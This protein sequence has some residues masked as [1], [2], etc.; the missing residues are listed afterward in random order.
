[1]TKRGV[2]VKGQLRSH[3]LFAKSI[4]EYISMVD[5]AKIYSTSAWNGPAEVKQIL[6]RNACSFVWFPSVAVKKI[7]GLHMVRAG[8]VCCSLI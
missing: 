1:V 3:K 7:R 2:P 4:E 8:T 6:Q 5:L